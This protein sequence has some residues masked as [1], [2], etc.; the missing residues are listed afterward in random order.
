[1]IPRNL[2]VIFSIRVAVA[3]VDGRAFSRQKRLLG[4][5]NLTTS[6][7]GCKVTPLSIEAVWPCLQNC[8]PVHSTETLRPHGHRWN[9]GDSALD[10]HMRLCEHHRRVKCTVIVVLSTV[11][12]GSTLLVGVEDVVLCLHR[13]MARVPRAAFARNVITSMARLPHPALVRYRNY[14]RL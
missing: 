2:G 9:H 1:M 7:V 12:A 14:R 8:S 13:H 6:T 5:T 4:Y 11:R 3:V 10:R